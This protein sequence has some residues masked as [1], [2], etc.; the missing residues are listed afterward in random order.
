MAYAGIGRALIRLAPY[1]TEAAWYIY[2]DLEKQDAPDN[3]HWK[4]VQVSISR[5]DGEDLCTNTFQFV[6]I[7]SGVVDSSWIAADYATVE[8]RLTTFYNAVKGNLAKQAAALTYRWYDMPRA[9]GV[10]NPPVERITAAVPDLNPTP[11]M[12]IPQAACSI[13]KVV[14]MRKHW[15]RIYLG[16]LNSSST[17]NLTENGRLKNTVVD[18]IATAHQAMVAG[19]QADDFPMVVYDQAHSALF[20]VEGTRVDN[21]VDIVRRR[22]PQENTYRKILP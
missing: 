19:L 22:R 4:K 18:S 7:T 9:A 15:G 12:L 10:E 17:D 13:T 5:D 8:A 16:P 14:P 6:N 2:K 11:G 1:L 3:F 20:A 21:I